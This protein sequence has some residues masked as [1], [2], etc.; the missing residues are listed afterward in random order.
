[1]NGL[2]LPIVPAQLA[3]GTCVLRPLLAEHVTHRYV[4]WLN[5]QEINR[6]LESRFETHTIDSVKAFVEDQHRNGLVLFYGIWIGRDQHIGN[7]KLGPVNHNHLTADVGFLIGER[8]YWGKGI[9]SE[10]I[11][12]IVRYGFALGL[13]KITAGAYENNPGSI[14]ALIRAGFQ[15]EGVRRGQIEFESQRIGIVQLG[16]ERDARADGSPMDDN[17]GL[18]MTSVNFQ[19]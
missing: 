10:A 3:G 14:K 8:N 17:A 19:Q 5:D 7:I 12:L 16:I 1:M 11:A 9:A 6:Y 18:A 4:A 2:Q 13:K 15:E